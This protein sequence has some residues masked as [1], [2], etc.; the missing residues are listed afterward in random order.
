MIWL[1]R[2]LGI[3]LLLS[4]CWLGWQG[5]AQQQQVIL[6]L[7]QDQKTLTQQLGDLNDRLVAVARM[8]QSQPLNL[9]VERSLAVPEQ[10]A[11]L[12]QN[13]RQGLRL[14]QAALQDGRPE[15][16]ESLLLNIQLLLQSPAQQV[17]APALVLGLQQA[18]QTD[19]IQLAQTA[20]RRHSA[21]RSMDSALVKIQQQLDHMAR[22]VPQAYL[23]STTA[24]GGLQSAPTSTPDW[25]DR[26][27]QIVVIQRV[28]STEH[29]SL[30]Q[31]ALLCREVALTV[32]LA[33]HAVRQQQPDQL[34]ALLREAM[35]QLSGLPDAQAVQTRQALEQLLAVPLPQAPP[36]TALALLPERASS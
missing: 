26:L 20:Q 22:H 18:L 32:G 15:D 29:V 4:L 36:L 23:P 30:A 2:V 13:I 21:R 9:A 17:L 14:A 25:L 24:G 35:Q 12:R 10:A 7:Q 33:R 34:Q 8:Q 3:L 31:R 1:W 6:R 28:P 5:Y 11:L 19:R 16:A 27:A